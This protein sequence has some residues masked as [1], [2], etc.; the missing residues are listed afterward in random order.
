[1]INVEPVSSIISQSYSQSYPQAITIR[2]IFHI[3]ALI[4]WVFL[5]SESK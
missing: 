4:W 1:M 2:F 5:L 3:Y